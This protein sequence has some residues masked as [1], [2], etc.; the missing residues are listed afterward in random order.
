MII[1][2]LIYL[3]DMVSICYGLTPRSCAPRHV[4][5]RSLCGK[6]WSKRP[7]KGTPW[8]LLT[9]MTFHE[10]TS[11]SDI[12]SASIAHGEP[13]CCIGRTS[14]TCQACS[15]TQVVHPYRSRGF[16]Q[17]SFDEHRRRTLPSGMSIGMAFLRACPG[18]SWFRFG[19]EI[20]TL[21]R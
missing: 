6:E 8:F 11:K 14:Q 10:R 9:F 5:Q 13:A 17:Q 4:F 18:L 21:G 20:W 15:S 12:H 3:R 16:L 1:T 2:Y 7:Q 19:L